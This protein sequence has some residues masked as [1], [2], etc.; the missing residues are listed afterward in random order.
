VKTSADTLNGR[1]DT[2]EA[3]IGEVRDGVSRVDGRVT[4]VDGRVTQLDSRTNER[5]EGVKGE[6]SAVDKK[7]ATAQTA[8]DRAANE[9]VILDEKFQNRNL[10]TV[11]AEKAILFKFD[12]AKLDSKYESDCS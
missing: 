6:V 7:A 11:A 5:F 8:A 10:F 12:S 1:I 4:G 2:N 9:V 3:E